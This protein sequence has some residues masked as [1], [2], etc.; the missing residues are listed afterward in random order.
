MVK[1]NEDL[2]EKSM[3]AEIRENATTHGTWCV[4]DPLSPEDSAAMTALRSAVAGMK[5]KLEGTAARGPCNG[6]M[7]RVVAPGGFTFEA[8]TVGGISGWWARPAQAR[9]GAAILHLPRS[10][11]LIEGTVS[12]LSL[13]AFFRPIR[14]GSKSPLRPL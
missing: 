6:M 12:L 8:D 2:K 11:T 3:Q 9:K 5:G 7:E 13:R 4:I 14:R 1:L 10:Q